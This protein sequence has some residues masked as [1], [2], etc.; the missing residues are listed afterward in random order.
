MNEVYIDLEKKVKT[1][2]FT[3]ERL[4][5]YAI[6]VGL[7]IFLISLDRCRNNQLVNQRVISDSTIQALVKQKNE[8]GDLLVRQETIISSSQEDLKKIVTENMGLKKRLVKSVNAHAKVTTN[9]SVVNME[10]PFEEEEEDFYLPP[11]QYDSC[12]TNT[13][14]VPRVASIETTDFY[15]KGT[16]TKKGLTVDSLS[17][18]DT[19][20]I[21]FV[22][23]G[24]WFKTDINGKFRIYK[25]PKLEVMVTHTNKYIDVK[26]L[27]SEFYKPPNK[28][29][30]GERIIIAVT[31]V[32]GTL[33]LTK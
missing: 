21:A 23:T 25:K 19:Q 18:P 33:L 4:I 26:G 3:K 20:N 22:K 11:I 13:I 8:M 1:K 16:V 12:D 2:W 27:S 31:A 24:G 9:T 28:P 15:F 17:L 29:R 5:T 32:A 10:V 7:L 30:W 6:I 14:K